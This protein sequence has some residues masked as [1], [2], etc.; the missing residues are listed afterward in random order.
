M[1]ESGQGCPR[2]TQKPKAAI[3]VSH[4]VANHT[5]QRKITESL[6][7][8]VDLLISPVNFT[9]LKKEKSF[10]ETMAFSFSLDSLHSFGMF[11]DS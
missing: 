9:V 11:V 4:G 1:V 5:E 2:L 10:P 3:F 8:T 7:G 6:K